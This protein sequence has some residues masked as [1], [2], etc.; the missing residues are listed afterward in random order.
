MSKVANMLNMLMLLRSRNKIQLSEL[1]NRLEVKP[2][3]IRKYKKEFEQVGIYIGSR[4]GKYGGYYMERDNT[5]L[6]LGLDEKEYSILKNAEEYLK[7]EGFMF[8]DEYK[9]ILDKINS[10]IQHNDEKKNVSELVLR[11]SPNI[12]GE[13]EKV[14]YKKMQEAVMSQQKVKMEY[15]SLSSGINERIIRPYVMYI[16]QGFWYI[17]GFCQ[18]REEIRQFKLSRIEKLELLEQSFEKPSDFSL[19]DYLENTV[20]IIYDEEKFDVKLE[21]DF[22][23]S[24]IISERN[25]VDDQEI[26]FGEDNSILFEA[27]MT[28]LEDIVNWVLSLGSSV[29]VIEPPKLKEKVREEAAEILQKN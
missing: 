26:T 9:N 29:K 11:S 23:M 12:D 6:D 10:N 19:G 5:I 2:R 25:W 28:G 1:A 21:I 22:P 14:K 4:R 15:F 16:Y 13:E 24:I 20:G 27:E 3:M 18:L 8:L 17:M 7:Q